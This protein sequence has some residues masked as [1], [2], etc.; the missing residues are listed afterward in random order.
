MIPNK[1]TILLMFSG[2]LDSLGALYVLLTDPKYEDYHIHCHHLHV[3][4]GN[5][6]I[7]VEAKAVAHCYYYFKTH[8]YRHFTYTDSV[9]ESPDLGNIILPARYMIYIIAG[10]FCE[11]Y[12]LVKYVAIG[13]TKTDDLKNIPDYNRAYVIFNLF[14]SNRICPVIDLLKEEVWEMLPADLRILSWSCRKPVFVNGI[15]QKC[16]KCPTCRELEFTNREK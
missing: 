15:A 5:N 11:H 13:D 8:S 14:A 10:H 7:Q 9:F 4:D 16:G 1:P 2:G 12:P 6:R 3:M